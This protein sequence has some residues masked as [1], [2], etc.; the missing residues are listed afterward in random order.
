MDKSLHYALTGAVIMGA[1]A[2]FRALTSRAKPI[3][4]HDGSHRMIPIPALVAGSAALCLALSV[5]VFVGALHAPPGQAIVAFALGAALAGLGLLTATMLSRA[6]DVRWD[7]TAIT[8][9]A[10]YGI[11]PFGPRH[12]TIRFADIVTAGID[13]MGS[14][15]VTDESGAKLR[16]SVAYAG[17]AT[18]KAALTRARPDLFPNATDSP[19][20]QSP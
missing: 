4:E 17:H 13:W 3:L 5:G 14:D 8:G 6:Y 16:W 15:Y 11:W 9:P 10:S 20:D 18:L 12:V 19:P 7:D 1:V 2:G